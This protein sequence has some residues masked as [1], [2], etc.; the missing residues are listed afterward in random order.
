M[1]KYTAVVAVGGE[2]KRI[3]FKTDGN[4]VEYLWS[5]YGMSSYIE[6]IEG[7]EEEGPVEPVVGK[8]AEIK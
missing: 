5:R 4:P 3:P 1:R 7:L 8:S 6:R 2:L